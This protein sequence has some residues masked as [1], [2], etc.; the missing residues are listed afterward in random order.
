[1]NLKEFI[2]KARCYNTKSSSYT[3][4]YASRL[5]NREQADQYRNLVREYIWVVHGM[6]DNNQAFNECGI[7][8]VFANEC[9]ESSNT[10]EFF[11]R[12]EEEII[13]ERFKMLDWIEEHL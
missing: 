9:Y 12:D 1:M 6:K 11:D 8:G 3:C 7:G 10:E 2:E 5:L 13:K 4:L